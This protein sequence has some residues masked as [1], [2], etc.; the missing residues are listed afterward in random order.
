ML[1]AVWYQEDFAPSLCALCYVPGD[2][3]SSEDSDDQ[4]AGKCV[5][6]FKNS[7]LLG[8]LTVRTLN[9]GIR[10]VSVSLVG[11][12]YKFNPEEIALKKS[13]T[14]SVFL[15]RKIPKGLGVVTG[16]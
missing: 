10:V 9:F 15:Q 8:S 4:T 5:E 13:A 1:S 7:S 6:I 12:Q 11:I 14:F 16:F 3:L 2:T